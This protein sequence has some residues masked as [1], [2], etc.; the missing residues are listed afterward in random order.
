MF[1]HNQFNPKGFQP[2]YRFD[3][4]KYFK[5]WF[6]KNPA[7]FLGIE[8]ELRFIQMRESNPTATLTF[9]Y[10]ST[11]LNAEALNKLKDF[12]KRHKITPVDFDTDVV[13]LLT[14]DSDKAMYTLA[15]E[16]IKRT[17]NNSGGNLA[18]AADCVRLIA[19]IIEKFGIYADFD[20]ACNLSNLKVQTVDSRQFHVQDKTTWPIRPLAS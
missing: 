16:E 13:T 20:L 1:T 11:C 7:N 17:L 14:H 4:T 12:C 5:I 2:T 18:A 9:V 15:Q 3:I 6:S 10:S 19:P 8:N